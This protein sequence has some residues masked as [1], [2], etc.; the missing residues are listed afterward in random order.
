MGRGRWKARPVKT[1]LQDEDVRFPA[2]SA[3]P[4]YYLCEVCPRLM[5]RLDRRK[6]DSPR[7]RYP[8]S[9]NWL[10]CASRSPTSPPAPSLHTL[11]FGRR[12]CQSFGCIEGPRLLHVDLWCFSKPNRGIRNAASLLTS[13]S[14]GTMIAHLFAAENARSAQCKIRH[15][16]I[17]VSAK[18]AS[19]RRGGRVKA[20]PP[21]AIFCHLTSY[22]NGDFRAGLFFASGL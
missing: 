11:M 7:H 2:L 6:T 16:A 4:H 22:E 18:Y 1:A 9:S 13:A 15:T 19:R 10:L 20:R 17:A 14:R 21:A 12:R 5:P 8:P 3:V